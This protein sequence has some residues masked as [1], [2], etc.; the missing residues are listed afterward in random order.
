LDGRFP[1]AVGNMASY[2]SLFRVSSRRP[3]AR[4]NITARP[5]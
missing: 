2:L 1:P 4:V 5:V 3:T